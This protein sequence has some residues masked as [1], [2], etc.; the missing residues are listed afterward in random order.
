MN[1]T[2]DAE[3]V[4]AQGRA[5]LDGERDLIANAANLSA[6][7]YQALPDVNWVGVYLRRGDELVLGPFQGRPACTR[8]ALGAG[9]C[10][11]AAR[12]RRTLVVPDVH[13]FPGHIACDAASRSEIVVPLLADGEVVGVLD[14]DSP[15]E[16]R[17]HD[18]ERQLFETLA[19]ALVEGSDR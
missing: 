13:A 18:Q 17:F 8:I 9:V 11:S 14:V 16:D 2:I 7:L 3:L 1:E 19:Q 12:E 15:R 5:L 4:I 6:L 10:G